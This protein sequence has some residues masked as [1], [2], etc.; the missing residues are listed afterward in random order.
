M[1]AKRTDAPLEAFPHLQ[2]WFSRISE[3]AAWKMTSSQ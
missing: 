2:S 1:H 3:M